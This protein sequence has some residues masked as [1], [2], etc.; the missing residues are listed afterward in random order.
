MKKLTSLLA[1][2]AVGVIFAGCAPVGP[3]GEEASGKAPSSEAAQ[4][5]L[6]KLSADK[7]EAKA[8]TYA[9]SL[10]SAKESGKLLLLKFSADWCAPCKEMS[11]AMKDD[12]LLREEIKNYQVLEVDIDDAKNKELKEKFYP[13]GGIP[14][15]IVLR[16]GDETR[17]TDLLGFDDGPTM[18]RALKSARTKV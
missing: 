8:A 5:T 3:K 7:G 2:I 16:P 18:A 4:P 14:F 6:G 9:S 11:K 10:A 17:V 15:V 12:M 13:D 1:V